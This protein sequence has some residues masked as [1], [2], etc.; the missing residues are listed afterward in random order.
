MDSPMPQRMRTQAAKNSD[1]E[2]MQAWAGQSSMYAQSGAAA[3]II[4][5]LWMETQQLMKQQSL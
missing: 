2:A 3:H 1:I 5:R 4:E